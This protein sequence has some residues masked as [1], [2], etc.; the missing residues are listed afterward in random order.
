MIYTQKL[1]TFSRFTSHIPEPK[2]NFLEMSNTL[3]LAEDSMKLFCTAQTAA[4]AAASIL[5]PLMTQKH[6]CL[7]IYIYT[8]EFSD[9]NM[10][11]QIKTIYMKSWI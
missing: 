7:Y 6:I 11:I 8:V 4:D 2:D 10:D 5:T 1:K 9:K 3:K